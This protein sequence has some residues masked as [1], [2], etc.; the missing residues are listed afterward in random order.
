MAGGIF[1]LMKG[2]CAVAH[3]FCRCV[4]KQVEQ[5]EECNAPKPDAGVQQ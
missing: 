4:T 5:F 2:L 1:S 3:G